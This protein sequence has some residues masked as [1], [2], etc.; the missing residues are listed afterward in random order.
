MTRHLRVANGVAARSAPFIAACQ[1]SE[2]QGVKLH[3]DSRPQ[4]AIP[5]RAA[6]SSP[7]PPPL[8]WRRVFPGREAE[9][10]ELRHWLVALLPET[11]YRDDVIT[12]GVELATN[13][14]KWT[15]SGQGGCFTAEITW[16]G[17]LVQVA[18]ADGG[19]PTEPHVIDDP[20]SDHGRGLLMVR[21]LSA[22][23]G[24]CG[25]QR[26][27]LVWAEI[28]C[29]G[30]GEVE[31]GS[32]PAGLE[33]AI[34][35]DH[36]ALVQR[37]ANVPIWFGNS[38][39]Q[40]WALPSRAAGRLLTAPSARQLADLLDRVLTHGRVPHRTVPEDPGAAWAG[41]Q[42]TMPKAQVPPR[43]HWAMPRVYRLGAQPC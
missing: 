30:E 16:N 35:D 34:R 11:R 5:E 24:V 4:S 37:F 32:F 38:T 14:L 33:A 1:P 31:P 17:R 23:V 28:L 21:A 27:R 18:V 29:T 41:D 22:G 6:S 19:A 42:V 2:S 43:I 8:R 9:I 15:A 3:M 12:V 13:A 25:D 10:R 20:M 7:L 39:L 36:A 40:W 26:G